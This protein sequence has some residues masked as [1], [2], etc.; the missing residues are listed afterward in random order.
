MKNFLKS[1]LA[2]SP[3]PKGLARDE[4]G[5]EFYSQ[6]GGLW[7]DRKDAAA[8][9]DRKAAQDPKIAAIRPQLEKFI[10]DGYVILEQAVAP[11]LIDQYLADLDRHMQSGTSPL[12]V[13]VPVYGPEDKGIVGLDGANMAAPLSKIL[14]TYHHMPSAQPM[15]FNAAVQHFL[16]TVFEEDL[17][18]F[19]GLHFERGSTQAVHQDTAYVVSEKPLQ[20]CASWLAL[21]DVQAGSGELIYYP[22]SHHSFKDWLYSGKYKHYNHERDK[23]EEHLGQ[24]DSLVRRAQEQGIALESFLP[25]KGD[26]LIWSADLAHGGSQITDASLTRRSLVTHFSPASST[27]NYFKYRLPH[28][29]KRQEVQPGCF[30]ASMYYD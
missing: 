24:L 28:Q 21:E 27:P 20:M 15:V 22:G 4:Q 29:R 17:W 19:Q 12:K 6:F 25:K 3:T 16:R 7:T 26:V 11:A 2:G 5:A 23:H 14:D 10:R 9:L 8:V 30:T 13:S 18:A 1:L